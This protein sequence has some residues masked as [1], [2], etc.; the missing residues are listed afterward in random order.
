MYAPR[1]LNRPLSPN[2]H[3]L[4]SATV[5]EKSLFPAVS[6]AYDVTFV[7]VTRDLSPADSNTAFILSAATRSPLA[8]ISTT[9][10]CCWPSSQ[11]G[12]AVVLGL[13]MYFQAVGKRS[14]DARTMFSD[15]T[16]SKKLKYQLW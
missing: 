8:S 7:S 15:R 2:T 16:R 12:V 5:R 10:F 1:R 14:I 9:A 4:A 11:S 3:N 6:T 13:T